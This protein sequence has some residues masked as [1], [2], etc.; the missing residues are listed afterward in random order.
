MY[1]ALASSVIL[2]LVLYVAAYV[3]LIGAVANAQLAGIGTD[4]VEPSRPSNSPA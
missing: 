2:S 4:Q 3:I 1:G